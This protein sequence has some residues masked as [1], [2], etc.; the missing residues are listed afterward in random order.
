MT[1]HAL[2]RSFAAQLAGLHKDM[3]A[4][5]HPEA[6]E[7]GLIEWSAHRSAVQ[8][9]LDVP[10][11]TTAGIAAQR[12]TEAPIL[13]AA[14]FRL[15]LPG[16]TADAAGLWLTGM[17]R[18]MTRD[19][20]P[21]DRQ[22]FFYRPVELLGIA[23]G[24]H[25]LATHDDTPL[26]WLQDLI[27]TSGHHL[28]SSGI[29]ALTFHALAMGLT[30]VEWRPSSRAEPSS[31][32]DIAVLLWLHLVDQ[33]L[34]ATA[35]PSDRQSLCQQLLE[36]SSTTEPQPHGLS[37]RGILTIAL[38]HAVTAAIGDLK[39]GGLR[40]AE[41]VVQLCRR[42]PLLA[43]EMGNRHA[44]RPAFTIADEYDLQDLLRAILRLHFDDVQAEQWNPS[45]GG[46]Q[47]RSDLLLRPQRIVIETKMTRR[48]LGQAEL[49]KQ[50]T[51]DKAQY[52]GNPE[53]G[54]PICFVYDPGRRLS[55]P[56]ALERDLSED[57]SEPRTIVV[58]SPQ[59]L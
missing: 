55:N 7:A 23:V 53:C 29:R 4:S 3:L 8:L 25:A 39:L 41:F 6:P 40:P 27:Q 26:R 20:V 1:E 42:F 28:P 49:V 24:S 45:Y 47:S 13:A 11:L 32:L 37:E 10:R 34:A 50:L 38:Q 52:R 35:T 16:T 43:A 56:T 57:D 22:S 31:T 9:Q 18:L 17:R 2:A 48:N 14:G 15:P 19:A 54:T 5:W 46:V 21:A 12:W 59:G 36:R 30:G 33:N 51:Q 58:V 44:R